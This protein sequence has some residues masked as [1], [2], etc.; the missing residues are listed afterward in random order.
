MKKTLSIVIPAYN[1][2]DQLA[3][4]LVSISRQ[5]VM[6]DEVIVVDNNSTD[7]SAKIAREFH[8]VTLI[9]ENAQGIS[10]AHHR[11][12]RHASSQLIARIDADTVLPPDWVSKVLEFYESPENKMTILT[13]SG[14][15]KNLRAPKLHVPL[16]NMT[17]RN[18]RLVLGHYPVW[19]PNCVFSNAVW[20]ILKNKTCVEKPTTY[21][22]FDIALHAHE[23]NIAITWCED[24]RVGV[25][26]KH[27]RSLVMFLRYTLRW[28]GTLKDHNDN[29]W[30][31]V[32]PLTVVYSILLFP[33]LYLLT[34]KVDAR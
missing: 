14:Y 21:D 5:T 3:E 16:M 6:P 4:C 2:E 23:S 26:I 31:M 30:L 32:Q 9:K 25:R 18:A 19:G 15:G 7:G 24:L 13:G 20:D 33:I 28:P 17:F 8:F 34:D 1:E 27:T 12:F 22:D 29:R 10:H 11:G